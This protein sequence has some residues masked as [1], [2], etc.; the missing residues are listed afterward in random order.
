MLE[1]PS[2]RGDD[3]H[4]GHRPEATEEGQDLGQTDPQPRV[5]APTARN[6]NRIGAVMASTAPSEAPAAAPMTYGS[7]IGL[8]SRA[9]NTTPAQ[10][11]PAPTR[12]PA[13]TRG[14]RTS[15]RM[16]GA[17][18]AQSPPPGSRAAGR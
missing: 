3:Q 7:A 12:T 1:R 15:N 18:E 17:V 9:W 16:V 2:W 13:R 5:P 6:G 10:P 14:R 8:R 11:R 4:Q